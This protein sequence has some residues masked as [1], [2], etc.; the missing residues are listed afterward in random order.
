LSRPCKPLTPDDP[1]HGTPKGYRAGCKQR[2]C[3]DAQ[4]AYNREVG[5]RARERE[6]AEGA[7]PGDLAVAAWKAANEEAKRQRREAAAVEKSTRLPDL[8]RKRF[9]KADDLGRGFLR[10]CSCGHTPGEHAIP[11]LGQPQPCDVKYC[12]CKDLDRP[13]V[14]EIRYH[15]GPRDMLAGARRLA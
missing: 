2:C 8:T 13:K 14:P 1:R 4:A 6:Q 5:R 11:K 7:H 10:R 15:E 3:M 9:H 12:R